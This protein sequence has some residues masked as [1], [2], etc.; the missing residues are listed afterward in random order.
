MLSGV[1]GP[2]LELQTLQTRKGG[3]SGDDGEAPQ[4][5]T[6]TTDG[7]YVVTDAHAGILVNKQLMC[8]AVIICM[9]K[10]IVFIRFVV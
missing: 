6:A 7:W 1:C 10:K 3:H 4:E 2:V 8:L 5:P 9:K